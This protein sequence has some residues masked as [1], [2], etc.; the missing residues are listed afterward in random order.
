M[1]YPIVRCV[2]E[3]TAPPADGLAMQTALAAVMEPSGEVP[4]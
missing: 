4:R 3:S 2:P 1:G